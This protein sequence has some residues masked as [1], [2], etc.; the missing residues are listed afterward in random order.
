M[1]NQRVGA[2]ILNI[3]TESLY[4]KPI[5]VFRE[6]VQNSADSFTKVKDIQDKEKLASIIWNKDENLY[7]LDNGKGIEK[8]NF[9]SEMTQIAASRKRKALNIGYKGI[10]RLSGIPYCKKLVFINI[11]NYKESVFQ[12]YSIDGEKY[13]NIKRSDNYGDMSFDSLMAEIGDYAEYIEGEELNKINLV[14]EPYKNFFAN[15]NTGFMVILESV[16]RILLDTIENVEFRTD[17]AWLLPV[18]FKDELFEGQKAQLFKDMSEENENNIIPAISYNVY[19]NGDIIERPIDNEMLRTYVCSINLKYAVGFHSFMHDRIAVIKDNPF[20][21]IRIYIDNILL[22][23]ENELL[24]ALKE[25]GFIEHTVNELIQSVKGIGAMIYIT[26]KVNISANARRTFIEVTDQ[27]S[28]DFLRLL[29]E[30]VENIYM[31]RY[32]LS[33]YSSAKKRVG[34]EQEKLNNLKA[35]ANE[36]LGILASQEITLDSKEERTLKFSELNESEQK[37]IIKKKITSEINEQIR[38]YLLQSTSFDYENAFS[39]FMTWLLASVK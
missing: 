35:K 2:G 29:A 25:Y 6:Y 7:F 5:V 34:V 31:A 16:R 26:D 4:D 28:I 30:F 20:S 8:E 12:R 15:R 32:A 37:Q 11:C 24:P 14:L 3:I 18:K 33:N 17:L 22:C 38:Q 1:E 27:D 21:G 9:F 19:F 13:N 23:D 39:D 36:A 10:G